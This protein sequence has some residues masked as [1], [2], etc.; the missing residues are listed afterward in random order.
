MPFDYHTTLN[1]DVPWNAYILRKTLAEK[2]N[3]PNIYL[4]ILIKIKSKISEIVF[5]LWNT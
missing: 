1:F 3:S 5:S 4:Y 2:I